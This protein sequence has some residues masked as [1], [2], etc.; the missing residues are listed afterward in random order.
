LVVGVI[1]MIQT[2]LVGA[3]LACDCFSVRQRPE[4]LRL[5]VHVI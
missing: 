4:L 3:E 5:W 1:D 2:C